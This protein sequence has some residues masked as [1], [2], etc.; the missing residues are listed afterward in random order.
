M[1][2]TSNITTWH[3]RKMPE[4]WRTKHTRGLTLVDNWRNG[5]NTCEWNTLKHEVRRSLKPPFW[6]TST[7]AQ[8]LETRAQHHGTYASLPP[9]P[10]SSKMAAGL[11]VVGG[12]GLLGIWSRGIQPSSVVDVRRFLF[13]R[14][15]FKRCDNVW[16]CT[17][18]FMLMHVLSSSDGLGGRV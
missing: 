6:R 13:F 2:N 1:Q 11:A 14:L 9:S 3:Q 12:R 10:H 5:W 7:I 15:S 18:M 16:N 4:N 8:V 17:K